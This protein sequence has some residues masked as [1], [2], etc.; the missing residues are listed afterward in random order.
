MRQRKQYTKTFK[1]L[2]SLS[3][4]LC[5]VQS[6]GQSSLP[7][8][9]WRLHLPYNQSKAIAET[10]DKVYVAADKGLFYYDKE[11]N[12]TQTMSKV[13]GLSEQQISTIA[14]DQGSKTLVIAYQNTNLDLIQNSKII[15]INDVLRKA[16][17]GDKKI[18]DIT[19][20][21]KLAFISSSFG[22]VVLDLVKHEVKDSYRNLGQNGEAVGVRATAILR[23]SIY[24]TTDAGV[25]AS[26]YSNT[27][28]QDF[29]NWTRLNT[30]LPATG[31]AA[32]K[33]AVFDNK[34]YLSL[35][36][37][38]MYTLQNG[39]WAS[40][41]VN[42]GGVVSSFNA[43][44]NF[45]SIATP[46]GVTALAKDG[47]VKNYTHQLLKDPKEAEISADG[48]V[49]VA[50]MQS[51]LVKLNAA[52][53][54]A[55][56]FMPNGPY[57]SNSFKVYT[58]GGKVYV[59]SG[60]Y[61]ASYLQSGTW[62]GFY[63][64][65]QGSWE[66]FNRYLYPEPSFAKGYDLVDAVYNP[67][68]E[69]LY[70]A[71]Y[72]NGVIEWTGP[73]S[74]KVYN[75]LNSTLL[76]AQPSYPDK[77]DWVRIT[78]LA[79]DTEGNLW[80]VNRNQFV[81]FPGLHMLKPD[82]TWKS[83]VLP[84]VPDGSNLDQIVIDDFGQKWLSVARRNNQRNGL[85]V[86]D[87]EKNRVRQLSVGSGF[88]GLPNGEVFSMAK[89]LNGDIWVGTANG[90]GVYYSPSQV[91][92]EQNYDARIPIV[93]RRPM[94]DGQIVRAIAVD[95]A[96]RKWMGTDNGLWLFNPEGDKLIRHFNASNSPLPS[97]KILS[98]AVEHASGEV[99]VATDAGVASYRA[100]ATVTEGTPEC[101]TVFP[102]PVRK[103]YTG[104]I[105]VSGLP[106]NADIRITDV[107]GTLV[108]KTRATGGTLAW[109]ARDYNGKRVRAGVYL[110]M[111]SSD[112]GSQTC[113]S[114]IAV[115]D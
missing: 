1:L 76:S 84:N 21:N 73:E 68:T 110:I 61:A 14:Y 36:S 57:S 40:A 85:V 33:L 65:D 114:K 66:S 51:G 91:F 72:G 113:I 112:D 20:H 60:G 98:V 6:Y 38:G 71:S 42:V 92:S 75:G 99:F 81:G 108:Y 115:L 55:T 49:W 79:V 44:A 15:N 78:S 59:L 45:L 102:N 13:D 109:D 97:N 8:G 107:A 27:N 7:I 83:F 10:A 29:R 54:E 64:Y 100:E 74:S 17:S 50:D 105:G 4:V 11:F 22:V 111:S 2:L 35:S 90:V 24:L 69:K 104:L 63:V 43:T 86:F 70:L 37:G 47:S 39:V 67:V 19:I 62:N 16:I 88:G 46:A 52:G 58:Y 41:A 87:D 82:S 94:L 101:A 93:D 89:D 28:L 18:N 9:N 53:T 26:R 32:D 3:V 56:A 30:G 103:D 96:N 31:T 34:L 106:N 95:G 48:T 25:L 23:D 5:F 80:A 77:T 12:T